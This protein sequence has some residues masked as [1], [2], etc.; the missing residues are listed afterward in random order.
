LRFD[1]AML[2]KVVGFVFVDTLYNADRVVFATA[3]L[4]VH[5]FGIYD[6]LHLIMIYVG[7][8]K[9]PMHPR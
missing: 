9:L 7:I 5:F 3:K 6:D 4:R 1:V 2:K 8:A